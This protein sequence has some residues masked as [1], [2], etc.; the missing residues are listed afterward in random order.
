MSIATIAALAQ[1]QNGA[2]GAGPGG[3]LI[4]LPITATRTETPTRL[5]PSPSRQVPVV[6]SSGLCGKPSPGQ[7]RSSSAPAKDLA[8]SMSQTSQA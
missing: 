5:A 3:N 2:L 8:V 1:T 7:P 6:T 4:T